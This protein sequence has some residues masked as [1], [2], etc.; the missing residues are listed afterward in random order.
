[1]EDEARGSK[2]HAIGLTAHMV[3]G[4]NSAILSG[5]ESYV[6]QSSGL[7]ETCLIRPCADRTRM[8]AEKGFIIKVHIKWSALLVFRAPGN[9]S[10]SAATSGSSVNWAD[11]SARRE[12][13]YVCFCVC[14]SHH[15]VSV[16]LGHTSRS[17]QDV[18]DNESRFELFGHSVSHAIPKK[19]ISV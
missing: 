2:S 1:M 9:Q 6:R 4:F 10:A 5:S 14:H 8:S 19:P 18:D 3:R 7:I 12:S 13:L 11:A 15:S 16:G 17:H